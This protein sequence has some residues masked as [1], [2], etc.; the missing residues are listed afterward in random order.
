MTYSSFITYVE[1]KKEFSG[2]VDGKDFKLLNIDNNN[3]VVLIGREYSRLV[4]HDKVR[5][6]KIYN[7][8][9]FKEMF[10]EGIIELTNMY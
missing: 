2:Y 7:D 5:D 4:P 3:I 9:T 6:Y 1:L 10:E 8:K